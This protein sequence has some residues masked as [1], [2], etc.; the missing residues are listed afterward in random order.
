MCAREP[1]RKPALGDLCGNRWTGS[2]LLVDLTPISLPFD[3]PTCLCTGQLPVL[4]G[5]IGAKEK[6]A[7]SCGVRPPIMFKRCSLSGFKIQTPNFF[8]RRNKAAKPAN[9]VPRRVND[10]GSG[11]TEVLPPRMPASEF[12][13]M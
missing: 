10:A 5:L 8:W 3:A 4:L 1:V 7:E 12:G 6:G 13:V 2:N 11:V 9:P